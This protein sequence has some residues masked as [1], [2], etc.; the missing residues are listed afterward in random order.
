MAT[1]DP[2]ARPIKL[3]ALDA[4]DLAVLSAHVQDATVKPAQIV[5]ERSAGRLLVPMNRFAWETPAAR[6]LLFPKYQRRN[7]VL[8]IDRVSSLRGRGVDRDDEDAVLS[9]LAV[10]A[11]TEGDETRIALRFADGVDLEASVSDIEVRL[12]DLGGAW[13]T[14][15]R[16]R[17]S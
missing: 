7:A 13:S 17:H 14:R 10:E 5:F 6:R 12:A 3:A 4:D 8:H 9:L 11:I 1:S 16:P 2:S 15:S